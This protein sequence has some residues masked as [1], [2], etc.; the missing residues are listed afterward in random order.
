MMWTALPFGVS[1]GPN[2]FQRTMREIF[3]DFSP[4]DLLIFLDDLVIHAASIP[5]LFKKFETFLARIEEVNLKKC[6]FMYSEI[7]LLGHRICKDGIKVSQDKIKSIID[8][9]PPKNVKQVRQFLGLT[10]YYRKFCLNYAKVAAP[11]TDLTKIDNPFCW[12]EKEQATFD[13]LKEILIS[14]PVLRHFD[15]DLPTTLS[16]D[17]SIEDLGAILEQTDEQGITRPVAFASRKLSSCES[18]IQIKWSTDQMERPPDIPREPPGGWNFNVRPALQELL[19]FNDN[20]IDM[21]NRDLRD[22]RRQ[23]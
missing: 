10:G 5:E 21:I 13:S 3:K 6:Q 15:E 12:G 1:V 17:A 14:T 7:A 23:G 19:R 20:A 16:C 9:K 22:M 4:E 8:A 18:R 11:L 2:V